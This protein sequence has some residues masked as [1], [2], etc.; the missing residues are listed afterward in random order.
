[1]LSAP[2][3]LEKD[4]RAAYYKREKCVILLYYTDD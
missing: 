4:G 2:C 3:Q 1:M